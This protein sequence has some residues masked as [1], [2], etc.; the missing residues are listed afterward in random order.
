MKEKIFTI[1]CTVLAFRLSLLGS[2][3]MYKYQEKKSRKKEL[4]F[5][6]YDRFIVLRNKIHQGR[7]LD[8]YD[9]NCDEQ[10]KIIYFLIEKRL[11]TNK[12]LEDKIYELM[13]SRLE[14]FYNNDPKSI[15]CANQSYNDITDYIF[16]KG[17]KLKQ[18]YGFGD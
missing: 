11:F 2:Y 17:D 9:L 10:E 8:F 3:I 14:N 16:K 18:K 6:F 13:C 7:A 5:N 1:I 12:Y 4:Y 15:N